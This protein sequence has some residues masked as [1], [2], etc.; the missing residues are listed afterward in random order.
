MPHYDIRWYQYTTEESHP[1]A[2]SHA[3]LACH[4]FVHHRQRCPS[5]HSMKGAC[6]LY[7]CAYLPKSRFR[8][9]LAASL[10]APIF[11][12]PKSKLQNPN[13]RGVYLSNSK[14]QILKS[15][16]QS[17]LA[18]AR[19]LG[20]LL[21]VSCPIAD[22]SFLST[23]LPMESREDP[24]MKRRFTEAQVAFA[25]RQAEHGTSVA[26]VVRKICVSR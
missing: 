10:F 7:P 6:R 20:D 26:E 15:K 14:I 16:L 12:N 1:Q 13:S 3:D 17:G 4:Q 24:V 22:V 25:L 5:H 9:G 8:L 19:T 2:A 23:L 21:P 18:D 11:H